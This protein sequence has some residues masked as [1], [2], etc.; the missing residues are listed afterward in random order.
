MDCIKTKTP[1]TSTELLTLPDKIQ[2]LEAVF[3][4]Y[5]L[6]HDVFL[7]SDKFYADVTGPESLEAKAQEIFSFLG[8]K[9]RSVEFHIDPD[10]EQLIVYRW[11][12]GHSQITLGWQCQDD[13]LLAG[14]ALAH[15]IVHHLLHVRAKLSLSPAENNEEL[16]DLGTIYAGLGV[17]ILNGLNGNHS[18][19]GS[20]AK[21]NY[22]AECTDYF[23]ARGIVTSLWQPYVLPEVAA[24]ITAGGLPRHR[25]RHVIRRQL[26]RRSSHKRQFAL[27]GLSL[28]IVASLLIFQKLTTPKFLSA[29]MQNQKETIE[30]LKV[31]HRECEETVNRKL[32]TWDTSDIFMMRQIDADK[33]RCASLRNRY[34][35]EVNQYNSKL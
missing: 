22:I 1:A 28:A 29:E 31:Q 33:S 27:A 8:M 23:K 6:K 17:L 25:Y 4:K 34:N 16:T 32:T 20:M 12:G 30:L 7:P 18:P 2:Q 10:S 14:A 21:A 13:A 15:A 35:Y 3:A 11:H 24:E 19:L 26:E 5:H 9:H